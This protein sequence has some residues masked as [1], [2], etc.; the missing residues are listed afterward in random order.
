MFIAMNRFRIRPDFTAAF[1]KAWSERE[2][3]LDQHPGFL[4]FRLLKSM[5]PA[6]LE[7]IEYVS[8][9]EWIDQPSFEAWMNGDGARRA[10]AKSTVPREAYLG[11]PEFRGYG[12][13]LDEVPG[14]RTD[15]RSVTMDRLVET[16]FAHESAAQREIRESHVQMG[17]PPIN[18]GAFEGRLLQILLCANGAK[19]GVEVGTLGGYSASWLAGAL[20]PN[21]RLISL[22][23]DPKRAEL[24]REN[25]RRTGHADRV[26][27]RVGDARQTLAQ[28]ADERDLDF[29]FIDADKASYGDYVRWAIPRLRKG[30]LLL[31]D[32]AY[33]WG[34]MHYYGR[35]A[36]Q[37]PFKG[38]TGLFDFGPQEFRGMSECWKELEM[39]PEFASLILPTGEG[40]AVAVKS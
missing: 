35:P 10:H 12:V 37:V 15:Y 20:P 26:E 29:V 36:D 2:S 19:R 25:L 22:E 7:A 18:I 28:M 40:L 27:V 32:N 34:G 14:H 33:I 9:S 4:R 13:A 1:E 39:H 30:G 23:L 5:L 11:P 16:K 6:G 21:G 24:A 17:L 8:H 3:A 31:A 38:G